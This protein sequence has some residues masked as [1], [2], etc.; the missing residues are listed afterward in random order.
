MREKST[1]V[2]LKL[3]FF[4]LLSHATSLNHDTGSLAPNND[5]LE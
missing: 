5:I 1:S 2:A 3:I 4:E